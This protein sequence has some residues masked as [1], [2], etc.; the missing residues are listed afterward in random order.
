MEF[1]KIKII[2]VLRI[3]LTLDDAEL[4]KIAIESLIDDLEEST[5]NN[6]KSIENKE[7]K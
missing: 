5:L 7:L 2:K 6:K 4:I 1:S 3:L